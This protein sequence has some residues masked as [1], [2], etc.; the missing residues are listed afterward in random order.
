LL[1]WRGDTCPTAINEACSLRRRRG[2]NARLVSK[3]RAASGCQRA[4]R[5]SPADCA[6]SLQRTARSELV[7][8]RHSSDCGEEHHGKSQE[9]GRSRSAGGRLP[10]LARRSS[11]RKRRTCAVR[12]IQNGGRRPSSSAAPPTLLCS[13][14]AAAGRQ[15][16]ERRRFRFRGTAHAAS[17]LPRHA[18]RHEQFERSRR[19]VVSRMKRPPCA[20]RRLGGGCAGLAGPSPAAEREVGPSQTGGSAACADKAD[21]FGIRELRPRAKAFDALGRRRW[22]AAPGTLSLL[23]AVLP[24]PLTL[25]GREPTPCFPRVTRGRRTV[26][27][28]GIPPVL[29]PSACQD[30]RQRWAAW[31]R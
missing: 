6:H 16:R 21:A 27:G 4:S 5:R 10:G 1:H 14:C 15:L 23:R 12:G 31:E 8:L 17:S 25:G 19:A 3:M 26:R 22:A 24:S 20:V 11:A 13:S 7:G 2:R 30:G 29:R 18:A 28:P 9:Q